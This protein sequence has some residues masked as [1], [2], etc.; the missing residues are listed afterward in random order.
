MTT[1]V[2]GEYQFQ[3]SVIAGTPEDGSTYLAIAILPGGAGFAFEADAFMEGKPIGGFCP[4]MGQMG[5]VPAPAACFT[6]WTEEC[7]GRGQDDEGR[8]S[9]HEIPSSPHLA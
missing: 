5:S 7:C 8:E 1:L 4:A 3:G 9:H 6:G 2:I